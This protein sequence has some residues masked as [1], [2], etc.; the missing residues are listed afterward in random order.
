MIRLALGVLCGALWFHQLPG[1]PAWPWAF[2][3][4][5]I[6]VGGA[7]RRAP[8]IAG[9]GFSLAWTHVYLLWLAPVA[10]PASFTPGDLQVEGVVA[11]LVERQDDRA[12][13]V[14][15]IDTVHLDD[16]RDPPLRGRWR[17]RLSWY[18]APEDLGADQRWRYRVRLRP[19]HGYANPG[20]F[21]Y[22]GW[23]FRQGIRLTGYVRPAGG[24]LLAQR[25]GDYPLTRVRQGLSAGL[26]GLLGPGPASGVLR[27]LTVGDRS[28]IDRALW[29]AFRGTGTSHLMAISGLHIG[30]VAGAIGGLV[31]L[32]WRRSRY[33]CERW[34][35]VMAG[36]L[37]GW[38][39]ALLYAL[40][41]GFALPTQ[42]AVLMLSVGALVLLGRRQVLPGQLLAVA[43]VV[44]LARDPQGVGDPGFWL[45][46][47]AVAII[48]LVLLRGQ[49]R[50]GLRLWLAVQFALTLGLAPALLAYG[51]PVAL[52]GFLANLVAI[53]LFTL[54]LV[55][56]ALLGTLAWVAG[57]DTT[58]LLLRIAARLLEW[59]LPI[60]EGLAQRS[61]WLLQLPQPGPFALALAALG[62][63]VLLLPRGVPGRLT[64]WVL[65][66]P[67]VHGQ[68]PAGA[69]QPGDFRVTV[70]DVGQGLAAVVE[71]R[72]RV[73]VF[74]AGPGYRGGLDAGSAV[75]GPFVRHQ[76]WRVIDRLILSHA[77]S[78]H[79]GGADGLLAQLPAR[80]ILVGEP[81]EHAALDAAPC[82]DGQAWRWDGV[83]FRMLHP[84]DGHARSGNAASCVLR[85]ANAAGS[86]LLTGDVEKAAEA[87]LV[88][89]HAG[90][91]RA[92][93]VVAP[94]H[95]S[96]T[97]ST[98]AF[99]A[100]TAP[101]HVIYTAG[102]RNRYGFPAPQVVA[103]WAA[104]GAIGVNTGQA[105]AVAFEFRTGPG[106]VGPT[107]Y[108]EQRR[109]YWHYAGAD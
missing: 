87:R 37:A 32:G 3:A 46:F 97:S 76:G 68:T 80:A 11:S 94:H 17:V 63:V 14:F 21:D 77:D 28:G 15:D 48:L 45:S 101:D 49:G 62:V 106:I 19:A 42:R 9:C 10:A 59:S 108:R 96:R 107:L 73:L 1:I 91:L 83:E 18:Q 60:L 57:V 2:A 53:P 6:G 56:L 99:V 55:P 74:D 69:L 65:L 90:R 22:E 51:Q 66:L 78:D 95:G 36:A 44:V 79:A 38:F 81:A 71:T 25:T 58:G 12:R 26:G 35:A 29:D 100:V 64:G 75:V 41:A 102:F 104:V 33:L 89:D 92:D 61:E 88:A 20:G 109:R 31:G 24:E 34:P 16:A 52:S 105:G 27:A 4:L 39:A 54:V 86:L 13:F 40:L 47:G 43:L 85:V 8:G 103:R 98:P 70:L 82:R 93:L 50:R 84:E 5:V 30:L 72:R 23:L 7:L 67:L